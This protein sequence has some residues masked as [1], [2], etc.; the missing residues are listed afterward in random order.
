[1][2][3]CSR[4]RRASPLFKS[5]VIREVQPVEGE[6]RPVRGSGAGIPGRHRVPVRCFNALSMVGRR[7]VHDDGQRGHQQRQHLWNR[8]PE[9]F[10]P[11]RKHGGKSGK[12]RRSKHDVATQSHASFRPTRIAPR[13]AGPPP[14]REISRPDGRADGRARSDHRRTRYILSYEPPNCVLTFE[15]VADAFVPTA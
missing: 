4:G 11:E 2:P 10:H 7:G 8:S 12:K 3:F 6:D 15:N 14:G 5:L 13:G 9:R 1:M